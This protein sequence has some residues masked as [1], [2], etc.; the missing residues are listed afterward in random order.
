MHFAQYD[1]LGYKLEE[2]QPETKE[3]EPKNASGPSTTK[4]TKEELQKE[5]DAKHDWRQYVAKEGDDAGFE[6]ISA[7]PEALKIAEEIMAKQN[8]FKGGRKDVD[9]KEED[10]NPEEQAVFT[11]LDGSDIGADDEIDDDF[12]AM[13]NDGKPALQLVGAE[14]KNETSAAAENAGVLVPK[15]EPGQDSMSQHPMM[16]ENYK[17]RMA[18]VIQMLEKQ[19]EFKKEAAQAGQRPDVIAAQA[20][21]L[22]NQKQYDDVFAAYMEKEYKDEQIGDLEGDAGV[23][24]LAFLEEM[25]ASEAAADPARL[26]SQE[27][28]PTAG[29]KDEEEY[30]DYGE[31]TDGDESVPDALEQKQMLDNEMIHQA[32]DEFIQDKKLWFRDLHKEHGED[33]KNNAMEKGANFLPSTALYVGN[34]KMLPIAGEL[35]EEEE[36]QLLK[37]RTLEQRPEESESEDEAE[38][39]EDSAEKWD[40]ETIL[41][42]YTNTDNHPGLI[43]YV[44]K[45]KTSQKMKIELHK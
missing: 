7:S 18:N 28:K 26:A 30:F 42:T 33:I 37:E 12:I 14:Q 43:K 13:L 44:P 4:K 10:M 6:F 39:S 40:A 38:S 21:S 24:P 34:P 20:R 19:E 16:I 29:G 22:V 5:E 35:E 31:L 25:D 41:S 36:K 45:V 11:V 9:I 27:P 15:E 17:E 3:Q 1:Q 23:D 8:Q 32:V 2:P